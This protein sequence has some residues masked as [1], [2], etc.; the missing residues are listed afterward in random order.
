[1]YLEDFRNNNLNMQALAL[2][3]EPPLLIHFHFNDHA[4]H[5]YSFTAQ[6]I[7]EL[8]DSKES[9]NNGISC[10]P[11]ISMWYLALSSFV[12]TF[13]KVICLKKGIDYQQLFLLPLADQYK[14]ILQFLEIDIELQNEKILLEK[15]QDYEKL[16]YNLRYDFFENEALNYKQAN[17]SKLPT[18]VN[19]VDVFQSLLIS[20]EVFEC[21]RFVIAGLDLMPNISLIGKNKQI[22][23]EKLGVLRDKVLS[24]GL[25]DILSKY[26]IKTK[27][28]LSAK[29]HHYPVSKLFEINQILAIF[30]Y[31]EDEK[32]KIS[33]SSSTNILSNFH[34]NLMRKFEGCEDN[35][36]INFLSPDNPKNFS[37][38]KG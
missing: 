25:K 38:Q 37:S 11:A 13:L 16:Y 5:A 26:K 35:H 14:A 7:L 9:I 19:Q 23:Y 29:F 32:Y 17:F 8:E 18:F 21:L 2:S 36:K 33:L 24:P 22:I 31:Q 12:G 6:C 15:I 3:T 20:L 27:L 4:I 28:E 34:T 1:M 10:Y 30:K